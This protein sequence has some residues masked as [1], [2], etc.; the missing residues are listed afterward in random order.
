MVKVSASVLL[1]LGHVRNIVFATAGHEAVNV[2]PNTPKAV[3]RITAAFLISPP[4]CFY[5]TGFI[6][7]S[8]KKSS[9]LK[10]LSVNLGP[11]PRFRVALLETVI[12]LGVK[13]TEVLL[14]TGRA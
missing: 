10:K 13:V 7:S 8:A 14:T 9:V 11:P 1:A 2:A 3:A 6:R 4:S 12:V 5:A